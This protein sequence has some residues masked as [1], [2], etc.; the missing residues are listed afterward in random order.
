MGVGQVVGQGDVRQERDSRTVLRGGGN[1]LQLDKVALLALEFPHAQAC[2]LGLFGGRCELKSVL[3]GI[4][5]NALAVVQLLARTS[6]ADKG[7]D[8][9]TVSENGCVTGDAT[10]FEDDPYDVEVVALAQL[11]HVRGV[12]LVDDENDLVGHRF[13]VFEAR[14]RA[15]TGEKALHALYDVCDVLDAL[16]KVGVVDLI[17]FATRLLEA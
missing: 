6:D 8:L 17:K 16:P 4:D 14:I 9:E 10:F 15:T 7:R 5:E 11:K 13:D 2:R 12:E 3:V 1:A